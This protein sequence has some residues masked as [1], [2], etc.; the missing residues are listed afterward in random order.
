M[1][2]KRVF[3]SRIKIGTASY[4]S[5]FYCD[6][7]WHMSEKGRHDVWTELEKLEMYLGEDISHLTKLA[8]RASR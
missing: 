1:T 5:A 8:R 2:L 6:G 3:P 4:S 7:D